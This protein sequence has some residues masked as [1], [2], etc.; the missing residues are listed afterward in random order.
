MYEVG[1][2]GNVDI[3]SQVIPVAHDRTAR[4]FAAQNM[5]TVN[6]NREAIQEQVEKSISTSVEQLFGI[7]AHSLQ[8]AAKPFAG[9]DKYI[10]YLNAKAA[11]NWNGQTPSIV[12]GTGAG[13]NLVIPVP[14][15]VV[16][17]PQ[18]AKSVP[19]P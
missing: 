8:I 6:Q 14:A 11:L 15:G 3:E 19:N 16:N 12:S 13:S 2:S 5:V 7:T 4:V 18:T 17:Q 9:P 1:R 10:Q